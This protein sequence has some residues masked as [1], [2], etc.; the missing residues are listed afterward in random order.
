MRYLR[1]ALEEKRT[2]SMRCAPTIAW[3]AIRLGIATGS[4]WSS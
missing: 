4:R 2:F 1:H 3:E